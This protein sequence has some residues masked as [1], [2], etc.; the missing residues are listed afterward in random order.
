D[1]LGESPVWDDRLGRL[2]W[3]DGVSRLIRYLDYARDEVKAVEVPS[4][5]GSIAL[6]RD[7]GRLI[8]GLADGIYLVSLA[9]GALEPVCRLDP[10]NDRV[11]F[12]DGK[13]DRQG[14]FVCGTMGVYAEPEGTLVRV[15]ADG[16]VDC[17]ATGIRISN[18]ICFS[19]DGA[20]L[21]FADSLDRMVRAHCYAPGAEPLTEPRV[22][23]DTSRFN[24]GPDGSTVDS[25]GYIWV[26][27][28][29]AGKIGRFAPDGSLDRMIEAPT[30][31]P[32]CVAFGGP[33]MST[34][35]M[36]SI[37]DSGSG[38]AI[39]RHPHGGYLFALNGLGVTGI[40]ETLYG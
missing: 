10:A 18:S 31:M 37:K 22:H 8:A 3:V 14:R 11:R 4:T 35:F 23:V 17:L 7:P 20:I 1:M 24:S 40:P 15:S 27:L 32:S 2:Y 34:L 19:P 33:D 26:S 6:C 38:R 30:D 21:Y 29:N 16:T 12:N 28:V 13:V 39:S 36:T 5:I 25:E 9:D